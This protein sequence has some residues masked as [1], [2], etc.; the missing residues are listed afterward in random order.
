MTGTYVCSTNECILGKSVKTYGG[1]RIF[2][3]ESVELDNFR[4]W[5]GDIEIFVTAKEILPLDET[6]TA[7]V[8]SKS[9]TVLDPYSFTKIYSKWEAA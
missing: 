4:C 5:W 1:G 3:F 2:K 9:E 6:F 8:I 7:N